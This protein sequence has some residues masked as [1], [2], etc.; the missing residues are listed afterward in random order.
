M[1]TS[2]ATR[3]DRAP[4]HPRDSGTSPPDIDS[5]PRPSDTCRY[6]DGGKP[7]R[8]GIRRTPVA[9]DC[10]AALTVTPRPRRRSRMQAAWPPPRAHFAPL[11]L[12]MRKAHRREGQRWREGVD[13]PVRGRVRDA[14]QRPDLA[15]G[16]VGA[17]VR[18]DQQ[19]PVRQVQRPWPA[20]TPVGDRVAAALRD[21]AHQPPK[22]CG[23]QPGERVDPLRPRRR[24]DLHSGSIDAHRAEA[25][26]R[27]A[28]YETPLRLGDGL[29]PPGDLRP[30]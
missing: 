20:G 2:T 13:D 26:L 29:E 19:D 25:L 18:G 3:P 1:S 24:D 30:R 15:H 9:H 5:R 6:R 23:L 27:H 12:C 21:Q 14:E 28:S 4:Y 17:P 22:L 11:T 7:L 8:R 10:V 16:Q